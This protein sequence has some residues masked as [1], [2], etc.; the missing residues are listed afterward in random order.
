MNP[1]RF[2]LTFAILAS[3][4]CLLTLTWYLISLV[5]FRIAE[6]DLLAQK[7]ETC[8]LLLASFIHALPD[9][10]DLAGDA[11][12]VRLAARL[13]EERQVKGLALVDADGRLVF[14]HNDE[15]G[16]LL[17]LKKALREESESA[18]FSAD[19]S[20]ITS[21]AP[22]FRNGQLKGAACLSLSLAGERERLL[23]SRRIFASYFLLDF[24]L[25][26]VLG[27]FVLSRIVVSPVNRLLAATKRIAAGDYGHSVKVSACAEIAGLAESFNAMLIALRVEREEV[28]RHVRS[29]EEANQQL[30][31]AREETARSERL[32]SV[33]LLAA[34][35]AHEIGTPLA[36]II[37]YAGI[38]RD[39]LGSDPA[40][41][42]YARRIEQD[43]GRID[44]IV[45]ELLNYARPS[46]GERERVQVGPLCAETL[47]LLTS[48]GIFKKITTELVIADDLPEPF[49]DR[50]Q[51][52]QVLINLLINARDALPDGG[53]I[54]VCAGVSGFDRDRTNGAGKQI[55]RG[56]RKGDFGD[57]FRM[58]TAEGGVL[59]C[60]RIDVRDTGQGIPE[61]HIERIFDP[62]FT[63]KEPGKGTGLGLSIAA[64]IIDS[65][66]G[67]IT[68]AS[69]HG[70]GTCF[71]IWL[72]LRKGDSSVDE[73]R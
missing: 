13:S 9:D 51:L 64:R 8:S 42:D 17:A 24:A 3:L 49:V 50:G 54:E 57:I 7:R 52:Q 38:L 18:Q 28:E 21:A 10:L 40:R 60:V 27:Y 70:L 44:R 67:R 41:A 29:L 6:N 59:Q 1:F 37:G 20:L 63:T 25:L 69:D 46:H 34:G 53:T 45:R 55:V 2:R 11:S 23:A 72:P 5:S 48:Q 14:R 66:G 35:T 15:P 43:A 62:F 22:V 16:I 36:A 56:R 73:T 39:D 68:V 26:L 12:A 58:E 32:A 71:S 33:G 30:K 19:G 4:A 61:E 47:S 31:V 65:F